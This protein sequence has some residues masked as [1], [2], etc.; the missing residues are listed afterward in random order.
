MN[1]K[2]KQSKHKLL[3]GLFKPLLLKVVRPALQ[4]VLEKQIKTSFSE[5]D[6]KLFSVKTEAEKAQAELEKNPDPENA[7]SIFQQYWTAAQRE[8]TQKKEKAKEVTA[9]KKANVA[10]TQ[11]DS[12]FQDIKLPGG[13]ST[14]AT[15]YKNMARE[16]ERWESPVFGI[17]SSKETSSLPKPVDVTRKQHGTGRAELRNPRDSGMEFDTTGINYGGV[18]PSAPDTTGYNAGATNAGPYA[19]LPQT[20]KPSEYNAQMLGTNV[21][22]ALGH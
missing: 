4:K 10:M 12:I 11:E 14:A 22:S 3:F 1:I 21:R 9:D 15:K 6:R 13:T 2:L 7:K 19:P 8:F 20:N 18:A 5:F 17:G 16:G